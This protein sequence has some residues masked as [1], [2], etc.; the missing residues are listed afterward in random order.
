ML[1]VA[2]RHTTP[3]N[4]AL[5]ANGGGQVHLGVKSTLDARSARVVQI[6]RTA[7][8]YASA[9]K[10]SESAGLRAGQDLSPSVPAPAF[11]PS[12]RQQASFQATRVL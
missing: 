7:S 12:L 3:P 5:T 4:T 11:T 6:L 10:A 2:W 1:C 8:S 9:G